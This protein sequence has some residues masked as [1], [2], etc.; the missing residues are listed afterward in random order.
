MLRPTLTCVNSPSLTPRYINHGRC[1]TVGLGVV[2][3]GVWPT[4]SSAVR[5]AA[6]AQ[7][8]VDKGKQFGRGLRVASRGHVEELTCDSKR[9]GRL[10]VSSSTVLER[11]REW[12][13]A[14]K[15]RPSGQNGSGRYAKVQWEEIVSR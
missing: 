2:G 8:L 1:G 9:E 14:E 13:N 5:A 10:T 15:I 12:A 7:L 6:L 3:W 4:F 11:I